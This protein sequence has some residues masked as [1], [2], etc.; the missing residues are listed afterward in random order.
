MMMMEQAAMV[1]M[2]C[3]WATWPWLNR[4]ER[5]DPHP[6]LVLPGFMVGD[7]STLPLRTLI[8]SWGYWVNTSGSRGNAGPSAAAVT[9]VRQRLM[10]VHRRHGRKV[11]LVGSSMGGMMA[12]LLAREYP[13]L[14]R[15]V[16]TLAS[17][18]QLTVDDRH[19]LSFITDRLRHTFDPLF[20]RQPDHALGQLPVPSTSLY[21]RSDGI[22]H[23]QSCLDV[24]D[25]HHENVEVF[26]TH[27]GHGSNPAALWVIA[28]RLAQA[29]D[30]WR[31]FRA[32]PWLRLAY[33]TPACWTH[34]RQPA[35]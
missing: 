30:D 19:S 17:P 8:R 5:G 18:L 4:L 6:V 22:V 28:D 16:I 11:T 33:P 32:P 27:S 2:V 9:Q 35:G 26:A 12:R 23:W 13:H 15:Q 31:P 25:D 3:T 7:S 20:G 10:D 21:T 29:E 34:V 24:V 14:V 1:E